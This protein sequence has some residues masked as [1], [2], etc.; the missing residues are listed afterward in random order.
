[1]RWLE[2]AE[3]DVREKKFKRWRH[4]ALGTEERASVIKEATAVRGL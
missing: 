4:K 2:D 1:L 3:K